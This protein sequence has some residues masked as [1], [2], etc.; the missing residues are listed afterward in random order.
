MLLAICRVIFLNNEAFAA[1]NDGDGVH[2]DAESEVS[3]DVIHNTVVV[4]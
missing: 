1:C 2:A 4:F 3:G